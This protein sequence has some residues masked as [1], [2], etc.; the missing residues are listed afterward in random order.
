[1]PTHVPSAPHRPI[2]AVTDLVDPVLRQTFAADKKYLEQTQVPILTV[3]GTYQEDLKGL[4]GL[5]ESDRST[6]IV[7]SRAHYS[8]A[9]A[10]AVAAWGK[11]IDPKKAWIVDPTNYVTSK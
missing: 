6:D 4:H 1:M 8:M 2:Q 7:L 5:P 3:S 11:S 9:L 10:L